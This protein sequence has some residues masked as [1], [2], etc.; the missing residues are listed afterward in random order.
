MN[1]FL[2]NLG[3]VLKGVEFLIVI[4]WLQ[5]FHKMRWKLF[6]GVK[7]DLASVQH[8]E[9]YSCFL[10]AFCFLV[11]HLVGS[12]VDQFVLSLEMDKLEKIKLFYTSGVII[13]F[14]FAMTLV[15]MHLVRGC[16]YSP[17]ARICMYTT[18]VYMALLGMEL[19]A[20]G[21]YDYHDLGMVYVIGAWMCNFIAIGALCTYPIRSLKDHFRQRRVA[22]E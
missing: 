16:T 18:L 13:Q 17:T 15:C 7:K 19:I 10:S 3:W 22:A 14:S 12:E 5:K 4:F 2:Y 8:H 9:L 1:E 21:S 11:F 6:F 20:R